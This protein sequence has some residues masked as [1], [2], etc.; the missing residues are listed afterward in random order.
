ME[1]PPDIDENRAQTPRARRALWA[2]ELSDE[3]LAALEGCRMDD[4]HAELDVLMDS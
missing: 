1:S 4:R 3:V 2:Y